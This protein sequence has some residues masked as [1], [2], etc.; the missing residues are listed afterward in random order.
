MKRLTS[1]QRWIMEFRI[2]NIGGLFLFLALTL[3][4]VAAAMKEN[5]IPPILVVVCLV[6]GFIL[7]YFSQWLAYRREILKK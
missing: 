5:L 6:I 4:L 7:I 2:F 3:G 1:D